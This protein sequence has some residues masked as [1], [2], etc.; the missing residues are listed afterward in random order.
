VVGAGPGSR[1]PPLR[2]LSYFRGLGGLILGGPPCSS[3]G[4]KL[5][6][7]PWRQRP[8]RDREDRT[9]SH[10]EVSNSSGIPNHPHFAFGAAWAAAKGGALAGSRKCSCSNPS[11][12]DLGLDS[13]APPFS[14]VH[15]WAE[16]GKI[17][18]G[19]ASRPFRPGRGAGEDWRRGIRLSYRR[20]TANA[21]GA[22]PEMIVAVLL[23]RPSG[24]LQG[25]RREGGFGIEAASRSW[26]P[27]RGLGNN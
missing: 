2:A 11:W 6:H 16:L 22:Y 27:A 18:E 1:S 12:G 24:A 4:P 21:V 9:A 13:R 10:G 25:P 23:L 5:G 3:R 26:P 14:V 15:Y 19:R 20:L 8:S 17:R 7:G